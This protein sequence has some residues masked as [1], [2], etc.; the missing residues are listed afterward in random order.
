MP[1][2][3]RAIAALHTM[4]PTTSPEFSTWGRERGRENTLVAKSVPVVPD[5][6]IHSETQ[7]GSRQTVCPHDV[8]ER[9]AILEFCAGLPRKEADTLALAEFG[10]TSWER[11]SS[12]APTWQTEANRD[13]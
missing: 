5:G 9:A 12:R 7:L 6:P 1:D 8:L 3:S 2:L 10:W 4:R 11:S 13:H